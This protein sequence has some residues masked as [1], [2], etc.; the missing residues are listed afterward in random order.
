MGGAAAAQDTQ[1]SPVGMT[2]DTTMVIDER[3]EIYVAAERDGWVLVG[4]A[5]SRS[6]DRFHVA[7]GYH[8]YDPTEVLAWLPHAEALLREIEDMDTGPWPFTQTPELKGGGP[9]LSFYVST[10]PP[11]GSRYLG[12]NI[13]SCYTWTSAG[14]NTN[15]PM[16]SEL[17][18]ALRIAAERALEASGGGPQPRSAEPSTYWRY[19]TSCPAVPDSTLQYQHPRHAEAGAAGAE[20]LVRFVVDTL[21]RV[22]LG[23]FEALP[24]SSPAL[25]GAVREAAASWNYLPAVRAGRRVRQ[26]VHAPVLVWPPSG[27]DEPIDRATPPTGAEGPSYPTFRGEECGGSSEVETLRPPNFVFEA[28]QVPC[29]ARPLYDMDV[30]MGKNGGVQTGTLLL[31]FVVDREGGADQETLTTFSHLS[32]EQI[33]AIKT[34][35]A[36]WR[37]LPGKV[38]GQRVSQLVHLEVIPR[39]PAPDGILT[40]YQGQLRTCVPWGSSGAAIHGRIIQGE[41]PEARRFLK[42]V[43]LELG[44]R[45]PAGDGWRVFGTE[46]R[47]GGDLPSS[48]VLGGREDTQAVRQ[49]ELYRLLRE[50]ITAAQ[51][52]EFET[53]VQIDLSGYGSCG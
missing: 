43:L 24:T 28:H 26:V 34:Q 23:S 31:Q 9:S 8:L 3:Y 7:G 22:D 16:L 50:V 48:I 1:T 21:G 11:D 12:L 19:A 17:V 51:A 35:M 6:A 39:D 32:L 27:P 18:V 5:L 45:A 33:D 42:R 38:E 37:F 14:Y 30:S 25:A 2:I 52:P 10:W 41:N 20:V 4:K 53:E 49:I 36:E 44:R 40:G 15:L 46:I 13:G 47:L 29:P